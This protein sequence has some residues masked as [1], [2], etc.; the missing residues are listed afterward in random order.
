MTTIVIGIK[1]ADEKWEQMKAVFDACVLAKVDIPDEVEM[2]FNGDAPDPSGIKVYEKSLGEAVKKYEKYP[3]L[4]YEVYID[5][6]PKDIKI[7]RFT[8]SW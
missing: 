4:G 1:P 5:K 7:I 3:Y 8:N 6:L 2:Y